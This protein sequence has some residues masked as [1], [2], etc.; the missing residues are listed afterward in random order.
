[1]RRQR[2]G[3]DILLY[4][5]A[6]TMIGAGVAGVIDAVTH[7]GIL[8][9]S[10][11]GDQK[12]S[13]IDQFK[14][15]FAR[16][17]R[18]HILIVG[19]DDLPEARG[20]TDAI[21]ILFL[22][23]SRKRAAMLSLPRDLR[24]EIPGH[25]RDKINHAY[26]FGGIELTR[27]TVERLL[28]IT[29]DYYAKADFKAFERIVD[30]LGG[31]DIDVPFRMY[32]HTYY[33]TINL[34]PGV[35]HLTGEQ[36]LGFV[37]YRTDSDLK[38]GERQQQFLRAIIKQKLRLRNIG[39]LAKVAGIVSEAIKTDMEWPERYALVRILKE[40]TPSEIMTAV[41]PIRDHPING[42]Y[43][44]E[45]RERSFFEMMDDIDSH[46][47]R[48]TGHIVTVEV[49]NGFGQPGAA[50]TAGELLVDAGF[51][52]TETANA[53]NFDYQQT[54]INYAPE[55]QA[56]AEQAKRALMLARAEMI[57]KTPDGNGNAPELVIVLGQ[58]F[59]DA[60]TNIQ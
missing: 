14:N 7:P 27:E 40:L 46:L 43:Y 17:N 34:Q 45:L 31:V 55:A 36:A 28:G 11:S 57:K 3:L 21:I 38:R 1:M 18:L 24:V 39:R 4:C 22:N 20:R 5:V 53:D 35:Q 12:I 42:I 50:A 33:G 19:A 30:T 9:P 49:L 8:V 59:K 58:D 52:V 47:D 26:H 6:A 41:V 54:V 25:G 56:G 16:V 29:I 37:R 23:P 10:Q 51:E 60:A 44:G 2:R 32:K 15:P 13:I 48:L